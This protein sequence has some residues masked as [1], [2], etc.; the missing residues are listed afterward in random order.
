MHRE[1]GAAMVATLGKSSEFVEVN[2][3]NKDSLEAALSGEVSHDIVHIF[4]C[5]YVIHE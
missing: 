4:F 2:I 1:K 3:D 5:I